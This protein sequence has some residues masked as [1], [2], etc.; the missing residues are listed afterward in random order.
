MTSDLKVLFFFSC[1]YGEISRQE[2][3]SARIDPTQLSSISVQ[4]TRK[5]ATNRPALD[6]SEV[7]E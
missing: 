1:S 3:N 5:F 4:A 2:P 6:S 7:L